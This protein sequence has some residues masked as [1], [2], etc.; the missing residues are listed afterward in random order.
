MQ[1]PQELIQVGCRIPKE[2]LAFLDKFDANNQSNAIRLALDKLIN[3]KQQEFL[4]KYLTLFAIGLVLV[5]LAPMMGMLVIQVVL[6][7]A[8]IFYIG[9]ST[10]N[11][12]KWKLKK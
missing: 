8:G 10:T 4:Q 7:C 6:Y 3:W 9:Y 2:Y 11:I 12:V 5:A 1:E